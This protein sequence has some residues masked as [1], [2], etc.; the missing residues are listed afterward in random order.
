MLYIGLADG[1]L[2][3]KTGSSHATLLRDVLLYAITVGAIVR[4]AV[5][6]ETIRWPP[7]SGWVLAWVI[8][9]AAQIANPENGT[10]AHSIASVRPHAEWVPLFFLAYFVMRSRARL[11]AF[12]LILLVIAAANGVVGLIQVNLTPGQLADWGPGYSQRDHRAKA[13]AAL[14][15]HLRRQRRATNA[16]GRSPSAATSASAASS[17]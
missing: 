10:L 16:T 1:Y 4:L 5:R 2:K 7:L 12:L 9:V 17:G 15:A 3:L 6:G 13:K 8:V 14:R 11:R